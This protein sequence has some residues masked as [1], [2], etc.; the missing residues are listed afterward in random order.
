M[1]WNPATGLPMNGAFDAMGNP[2]GSGY[3]HSRVNPATGLPMNGS[4]DVAGNP[5]GSSHSHSVVNPSGGLAHARR[6]RYGR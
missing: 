4:L 2:F 5:F 1:K 3:S 6:F